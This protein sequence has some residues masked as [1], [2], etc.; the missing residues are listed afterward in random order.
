MRMRSFL[1]TVETK[2]RTLWACQPL[3]ALISAN[4]HRQAALSVDVGD[5]LQVKLLSTDPQRGY[6]DFAR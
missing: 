5:Q 1:A 2:A 4:W 6:L 3:K